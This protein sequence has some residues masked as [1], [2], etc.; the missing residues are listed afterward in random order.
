MSGRP[1]RVPVAGLRPGPLALPPEAARYVGTVHRLGPGAPLVLVDHAAR[2]EAS[3]RVRHVARG[4]VDVDVDEPRPSPSL[5]PRSIVLLQGLPKG[6]KMDAIVRD[7]TELGVARVVPIFAARSIVRP[8]AGGGGRLERWRR[9]ALEAARQCGR[10][11]LPEVLEP[12][13]VEGAFQLALPPGPRLVLEPDAPPLRDAF[14]PVLPAAIA[15][16][17]GPE[18]GWEASEL[19]AARAAGWALASLGPFV[20]RTETAAAAALGA[21]WALAPPGV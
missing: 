6:D 20:L 9:V 13:S 2:L 4:A 5:P 18:G 7:A 3:A 17:V 21:L 15:F 16:A 10:G 11:D 14:G 8:G 1:L 19:D 12:L